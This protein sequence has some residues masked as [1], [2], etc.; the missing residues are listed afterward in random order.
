[1]TGIS[2]RFLILITDYGPRCCIEKIVET[3]LTQ[4]LGGVN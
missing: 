4:A 3:F 2:L 1:M